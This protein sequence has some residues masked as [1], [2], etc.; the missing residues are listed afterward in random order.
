LKAVKW[1]EDT[2]FA[3][4]PPYPG[5]FHDP[6]VEHEIQEITIGGPKGSELFGGWNKAERDKHVKAAMSVLRSMGF[7]AV[8][9][10]RLTLQDML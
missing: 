7:H 1:E 2:R 9:H 8:P 4:T 3:R 10:R 5:E 6:P